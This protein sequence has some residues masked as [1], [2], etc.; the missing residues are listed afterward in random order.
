MLKRL[1]LALALVSL[2]STTGW[3]QPTHDVQM[4]K[5]PSDEVQVDTQIT[6]GMPGFLDDVDRA[7][8]SL[9]SNDLKGSEEAVAQARKDLAKIESYLGDNPDYEEVHMSLEKIDM[10]L[11]EGQ[12]ALHTNRKQL[13]MQHLT[14]A[15]RFTKILKESPVAK[16]TG[17][18]VALNLA[19]REIQG[20]NY[21]SAGLYLQQAIDFLTA[22]QDNGKV[23][24]KSINALK[25]DIVIAH[26]QVILGK[27][28]KKNYLDNLYNRASAATSNAMYQYYD[29]WTMTP[30]PWNQNGW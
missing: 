3:T 5:A 9:K 14:Q 8:S 2:A 19:N 18:K 22:I 4:G 6:Q 29:M 11:Q 26:Q 16:L 21:A 24:Q 1:G 12:M 30:T 7:L 27:M 20:G 28:N 10:S 13:A 25:N 23:D 15:E 17:T